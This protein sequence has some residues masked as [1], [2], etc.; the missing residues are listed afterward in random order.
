MLREHLQ[1]GVT[2]LISRLMSDQGAWPGTGIFPGM[3]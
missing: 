2:I 1:T 3:V